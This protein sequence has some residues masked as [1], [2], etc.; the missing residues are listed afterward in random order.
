MKCYIFLDI[1]GVLLPYG[2]GAYPSLSHSHVATFSKL[3]ASLEKFLEVEIVLSSFWRL[4]QDEEKMTQILI[5]HG[6]TGPRISALTPK[7]FM[8]KN[9]DCEV[10]FSD[11]EK[12][13]STRA[14]EIMAF[15]SH[16][17]DEFKFLVIDD[18]R[19]PAYCPLKSRF[20][21]TNSYLGLQKIDVAPAIRKLKGQKTF[22]GSDFKDARE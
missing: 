22:K 2:P 4:D 13:C 8:K 1:D 17:P 20:I 18:D 21:K 10:H 14:E 6:Y 19:S 15:L 3:V 5:N 11:R 12:L 16:Q 7:P 9:V